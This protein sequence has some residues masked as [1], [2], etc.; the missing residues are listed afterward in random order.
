MLK[1]YNS[2]TKRDYT[3]F[4]GYDPISMPRQKFVP[5]FIKRTAATDDYVKTINLVNQAGSLTDISAYFETT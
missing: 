3:R 4:E 5:W 2:T 1:F